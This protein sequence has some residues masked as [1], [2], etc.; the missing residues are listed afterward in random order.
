MKPTILSLLTII[1]LALAVQAAAPI[2]VML[3]DGESGGPYHK[4]QLVT[5][6]LKKQLEET[7][8]FQVEVVTAPPAKGDFSNFKPEFSKYQVIVMNY[9]APDERWSAELKSSFEQY[10]KNGG[11]LVVVHAAN[12]AFGKWK[13]FNEMI[14]IGGWRGRNEASGP[15][16]FFKDGKL[17]SDNAPGNAGN[18]GARQPYQIM[19]HDT[20]HP[21]TK[22]LP[23]VWMHQG[24]E[25][26]TNL[27]GP[28]KNMNVLGTA[29]ADPSNR[30]TNRDEPMLMTLSYGKGKIFHTAMG[31]D[32]M[33]LS[34]VGAITML[35]RGTEWAATGKVTQK[36]PANFPTANSVSYRTDYAAMDPNYKKGL[37]GLDR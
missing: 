28:G 29:F 37:N 20:K 4:W 36:V 30:G 14:G 19:L 16:W 18:H 34:C 32:V 1:F 33:A 7:G 12:N 26:Y 6:V 22:G 21:V 8:L 13:E 2:R 11:G 9:D 23:K 5:P 15:L 10:V 3:L 27:R 31:H 17:T 25:L 35:Q 24:D